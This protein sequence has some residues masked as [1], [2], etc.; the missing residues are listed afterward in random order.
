MILKKLSSPELISCVKLK[1]EQVSNNSSNTALGKTLF[2]NKKLELAPFSSIDFFNWGGWEKNPLSNRSWQ[3]RLNWL[4]FLSYLI[5]YH[6]TSKDDDVL[7]FS[8]IAIQSWLDSYLKTDTSYP[9]EFIWHDHATALRAEQLVLFVYYCRENASEWAEQHDDFLKYVEHALVVHAQWLAKDS[10]YSEHT[11]HGLEQA[12]VLLLLG[13]VFEGQNAHEW[14]QIAIRRITSELNFAFTEEGVHVENSPAYHVFVFKVFIGIIKDYPADML[15]DL[16]DKFEQFSAKALSFITYVLRPD[17]SLPPIGDTEQLPTSDAYR[18]MFGHTLE[19]KHFLYALT[20]GKKGGTP[21]A[22]NK[23]YANSGYA[24][25]RDRWPETECFEQA[26]HI[27]MKLGCLSRYH[28]QQDEGHISVYGWGEDWLIDSGLYNYI[29]TDPVRKYMRGRVGHNVPLINGARYST[30]FEHRLNNWQVMEFSESD[31]NPGVTLKLQVLEPVIQIRKFDFLTESKRLNIA[32][33]FKFTDECA[34]DIVLQWHFPSDK[35]IS[36]IDKK[37]CISS[38]SGN[39][40]ILTFK[41]EQPDEIHLL[42]GRKDDRVYSCISYKANSLDDSQAVRV[43]F[44]SRYSLD[45]ESA[46][47]FLALEDPLG[48]SPAS[49]I[50]EVYTNGK[51]FKI[52]LPD[53]KTDY[54]QKSIAKNSKPYE[55]EMLEAMSIG[56]NPMDLVLDVGANIGNHTLYFAC[57]LGCQVRAYEPNKRLHQPLSNSVK[58]NGIAE[59]VQVF[60]CGV[61]RGPSK[62]K[63]KELNE[64][65]LG[66]QS[67]ELLDE[68]SI[69]IDVVRLDDQVFESPVAAIKIDVEGMELAVLEGAEDLIQKDQ[70][71]LVV[72]SVDVAHYDTLQNFIKRNNYIYCSSFNG[73]PTHFFIHQDK[74][75]GSP[76]IDLFFAKGR[77]FYQMRHYHKKLKKTLQQLNKIK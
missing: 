29:N 35:T 77:E 2:V 63:L 19:Y 41:N 55:A 38:V 76:W 13:T 67:L 24:V 27:I 40:C 37:V 57:V 21:S 26:F 58:L 34:R 47:E 61:G 50:H 15:G 66:S 6:C 20:Q 7:S 25:F 48:L 39:Q 1:L 9:F 64:S 74:V 75:A 14:Q 4:S 3:W 59:L 36:V 17:G 28:H 65:N 22:L 23:V 33:Y 71:L 51:V 73:T 60:P 5:A 45:V 43:V 30:E 32:D 70:P 12:R 69:G 42:K 44:K 18:Q 52:D 46:F 72:E 8:K 53:F 68:G 31:V 56:L 62:A 54:I 10:F 49:T 16:A 11:N